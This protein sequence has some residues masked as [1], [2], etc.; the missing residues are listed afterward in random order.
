M[1]TRVERASTLIRRVRAESGLSIR[2]VAERAQVAASTISRIEAGRVDPG[3][4][5]LGSVLAAM[6]YELELTVRRRAS[7]RLAELC[8]AKSSSSQGDRLDWTRLRF[9][10]DHLARN[11]HETDDAIAP[12]PPSSGSAVL[13]NALA[14]LAEKVADD[15][16]LERPSWAAA[17]EPLGQD[18]F[19]APLT[20]RMR[21]RVRHSTP[22]QF[23][24]RRLFVDERSLWRGEAASA[25]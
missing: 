24:A 9:F 22:A 25:S 2:A 13:D 20:S 10:L 6:G 16:G 21:D 11:P 14:A 18:T 15:A 1:L 5:T 8:D 7:V 17:I 19:P 12:P 4:E 3:V 23:A